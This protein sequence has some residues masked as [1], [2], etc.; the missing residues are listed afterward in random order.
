MPGDGKHEKETRVS[1]KERGDRFRELEEAYK[2]Y[3]V[4]D[5]H[6]E[7]IGKVDDLFVDENDQPE[8]IGVKTGFLGSKSTLIPM[9]IVRVNDRRKLIEVAADRDAV[10]DAPSFDDDEQI[11]P[12]HEDR[13]YGHFG[14]ERPGS[15]QERGAY[16][17]YYSSGT[18]REAPADEELARSVDTEYGERVESSDRSTDEAFSDETARD[19]PGAA[20]GTEP[21]GGLGGADESM[22]TEEG[23]QTGAGEP[24]SRG[25]RVYK[26]VRSRS[27]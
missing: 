27:G 1:E 25:M 24:E 26:R 11:T 12:D 19:H 3:T 6:Y 8:Y 15:S 7:K 5:Q 23:R 22:R 13:I 17:D 18:A 2:D 10:K 9:E 20:G 21:R 14:L 16:G 4:Y